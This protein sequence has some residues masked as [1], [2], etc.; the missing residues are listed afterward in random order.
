MPEY[1]F[2]G[3]PR[4]GEKVTVKALQNKVII[5]G[6]DIRYRKVSGFCRHCHVYLHE[7]IAREELIPLLLESYKK[8]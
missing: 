7:D 8:L 3:G 1:L 2:I 5:K 6:T 4:D